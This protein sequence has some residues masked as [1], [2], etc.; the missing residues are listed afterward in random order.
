MSKKFDYIVFI[1]RF[2]PFHNGHVSVINHAL[3]LAERVVVVRGGHGSPRTIKNPFSIAERGEM[4]R[5]A[6]PNADQVRLASVQDHLYDDNAWV[7]EVKAMVDLTAG[8]HDNPNVGIMVHGGDFSGYDGSTFPDWE[9]VSI[10]EDSNN[11]HAT[12]I[13]D[14]YFNKGYILSSKVPKSTAK[15]MLDHKIS[16]A[17][18]YT[19]KEHNYIKKYKE[20]YNALP[21]PPI[22][23]TVDALILNNW[24]EVLLIKRGG[25][26]GNGLWALPGGFVDAHETLHDAV[27]REVRE[28]TGLDME[29]S[30]WHLIDQ[31][32]FD[33]P[34]RS[35]LGRLITNC[36]E[37]VSPTMGEAEVTAGD[38]ATD[39]R[40]IDPKKV[41]R[42]MMHDDHYYIIKEMCE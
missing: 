23:C 21:Y 22:F 11:V 19:K 9:A 30:C 37:F 41:T 13:R 34:G 31:R 15:V 10:V 7:D 26:L 1:G 12:T 20:P 27:I 16:D 24:G 38:D 17:F 5:G 32:C 40:W 6:F 25:E 35:E 14:S 29:E 33:S 3:T 28:E 2:Q 18:M 39:Y 4:I 36:F 42:D 8:W